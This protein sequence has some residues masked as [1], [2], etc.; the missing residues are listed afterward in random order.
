[1]RR[2]LWGMIFA[3]FWGTLVVAQSVLSVSTIERKPFSFREDGQW[4]GF[5]I[6]LLNKITENLGLDTNY[7]E[8][9]MFAEMLQSAISGRSDLAVANISITAE[10]EA[11]MDFTQPI[12]D[13]GLTILTKAGNAPSIFSA[14]LNPQLFLLALAAIALF[15]IAGGLVAIFERNHPHFKDLKKPKSLEEGV[16]WAVSVVTNASFTIFTP[17]TAAGRAMAYVLIL[18]GLFVVSAFVAQITAS[19]TVEGLRSQVSTISDLNGKRVGTTNGSTSSRFL[20]R[21]GID[22]VTASN[23]EAL[24]A[25]LNA[26]RLDAIVHDA[27]IL[28]YYAQTD[29]RGKVQTAGGI[30]NPEKY[31]IALPP[32]SSLREQFNRE[33]L[34]LRENGEYNT[35]VQKWFGAAYR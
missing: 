35:L 2:F 22:H 24:Y 26:G 9:L 16:W 8:H 18:I 28:A 17:L 10:R 32:Q 3:T 12:F 23:L 15:L 1:M 31:G 7:T 13:S 25:D 29:G 34:R 11:V 19:L 20:A 21:Q 27:P 30:F 14:I 33:L 5:S 6:E 4:T